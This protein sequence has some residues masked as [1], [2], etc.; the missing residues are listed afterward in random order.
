MLK[1]LCEKRPMIPRVIFVRSL[2]NFWIRLRI[3]YIYFNVL[4]I[5]VSISL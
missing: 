3:E 4:S 1:G 5:S 2:L